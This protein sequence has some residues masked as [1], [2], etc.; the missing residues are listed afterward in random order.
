LLQIVWF[1]LDDW[2]GWGWKALDECVQRRRR[3]GGHIGLGEL[4]GLPVGVQSLL[5]VD[6]PV[7]ALHHFELLTLTLIYESKRYHADYCRRPG[8]Y[9]CGESVA[10]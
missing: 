7:D 1:A 6:V 4:L 2:K 10:S 3:A 5:S 8:D 9:V